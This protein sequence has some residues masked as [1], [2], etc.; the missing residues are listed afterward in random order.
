MKDVKENNA[1]FQASHM[2]ILVTYTALLCAL[3]VE[4]LL[5]GWEKWA[6]IP[7]YCA[8]CFCWFAHIRQMFADRNRLLLYIVCM[9]LTLFFYGIHLTS[10]FDLALVMSVAIILCTTTGVKLFVTLCQITYF[11][12]F[13]YDFFAILRTSPEEL[14]S[15]VISRIMLHVL[16]VLMTGWLARL[17]IDRWNQVLEHS[18]EEV[19]Q[20]A[21]ATGRLNDFLTSVSHEIRTPINAVLGLS[22]ICLERTED[23]EEQEHLK[24]IQAAGKRMTE[25]ISDI[26]DYSDIDRLRIS[27]NH[28]NYMLSSVLHDL[29]AELKPYMHEGVE[30]IIDVDPAIPNVMNTDVS[31]LKKIFWHLISNALKFT[32][33]GGVYVRISAEIQDYGINLLLDVCDTGIGM[34]EEEMDRLYEG[35]YQADSSRTRSSGGLGLGMSI[36]YGFVTALNG[37]IRA[38]SQPGKGTAVHVCL[39]QEVVDPE[40]C[41]SVRSREQLVVGGYL[42]FEKY[43]NPMVRDYYNTMVRNI[44][45][46]LRVTMRRV[47]NLENLK[48][49]LET[50]QLTHLFVGKEEYETDAAFMEHLAETVTVTVVADGSFV[51]PAGSR[52]HVME[53][54]FY[55]FPV[56][57]VLNREPG[58]VLSEQYMY[59]RGVRAL[60]VDDEPL[61]IVVARDILRRYGIAVTAAASGREAISLCAQEA[62][63]IVFMDHMMP[64]MDGIEVMTRIRSISTGDWKTVPMIALT[65]NAGSTARE[66]FRVAGFDGFIAKP[67]DLAELE[68]VL[69]AVLPKSAI[70][71]E[72]TPHARADHKTRPA[73]ESDRSAPAA[74]PDEY[75][76]LRA[77]GVDIRQGLRYCQ[78]DDDFYQT[79]LRQFA[80]EAAEKRG[81]MEAFVRTDDMPN[82]AIRIHALKSTAKMIGAEALSEKAKALEAASKAGRSD[83]V[84]AGH[85]AAMAEYDAVTRAIFTAFGGAPDASGSAGT[86][87]AVLEFGPEP[88]AEDVLEF[89][90]EE[91]SADE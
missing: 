19:E 17:I 25:L 64:G 73:A 24:S 59:C 32:K 80:S 65:A 4:T 60:V 44:V 68:R 43:P 83:E 7:I 61:N 75:A 70:T 58:A 49:L 33:E 84:Q 57:V 2:M 20:L 26:L 52:A 35:F 55:C 89:R 56:A 38:E 34:T 16:L 11:V 48:K 86:E 9:M 77:V 54:P 91:A 6:L 90:P 5:M 40:S 14:D 85:P 23:A 30:L 27:M 67:I 71:Y 12:T 1:L 46:G 50:I 74:P 41:M 29:T 22:G 8:L 62:Y 28:E 51:L 42:H 18:K 21:E 87:D 76:P 79:L 39:P 63:D 72:N 36:V 15:L 3:T 47:D 31:K 66:A 45:R 10:T 13:I 88:E 78:S 81:E 69:R 37:F 53:K 82:Y